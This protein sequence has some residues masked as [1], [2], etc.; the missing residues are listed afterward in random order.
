MYEENLAY[1][2]FSWNGETKITPVNYYF[3]NFPLY[4]GRLYRYLKP[5]LHYFIEKC[6]FRGL[7]LL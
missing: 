2:S 4:M 5:N 6:D 7:F 1:N 3:Q